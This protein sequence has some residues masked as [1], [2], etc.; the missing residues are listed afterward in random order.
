MQALAREKQANIL[1][2]RPESKRERKLQWFM[3]IK[4]SLIKKL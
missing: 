2:E 3:G 1:R 4:K